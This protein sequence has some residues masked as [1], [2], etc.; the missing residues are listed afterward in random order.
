MPEW[1]E[2]EQIRRELAVLEGRRI[3]GVTVLCE[4]TI[5]TPADPEEF[6]ARLAGETWQEIGRRGKYLLF[7]GLRWTLIS[8][9]RMEGRYRLVEAKTPVDEYTRVIF[10][11][12]DGR[13]LRY[14]DVRK[15]GTMDAVEHRQ[16]EVFPPIASLGPEPF[17]PQLTPEVLRRRLSGKGR[18]KGLLLNQRV[19]AGLGNIYVDEVLF[20]TGIHPER[21]GRSLTPDE[22]ERL[23]AQMR[24]LLQEALAAGGATVRSYV[25]SDG[26]PGLMQEHLFVYGRTGQPCRVCGHSIERRVVA[27]RGTHI[28]PVCQ[29]EGGIEA[30]GTGREVGGPGW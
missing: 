27:G 19:I 16:W 23:L 22:A 15:F 4:R 14:R 3:A 2:V 13:D 12:E 21:P 11:L 7:H 6:A 29:P 20:R 10:H 17:D 18:I 25:R 26:R 30:D 24:A 9:L 8:H 1:P 28:C 5:R